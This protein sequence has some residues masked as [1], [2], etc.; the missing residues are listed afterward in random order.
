MSKKVIS[1]CV[2]CGK[3]FKHSKYHDTKTCSKECLSEYRWQNFLQEKVL[4]QI[5][6]PL[7][8]WLDE[9]YNKE[10]WSYRDFMDY[11]NINNRTV[12]KLLK[13]NNIKIRHGSKAVEAQYKRN[14]EL[15]EKSRKVFI[16]ND[17]PPKKGE[18]NPAQNP[19]V[20]KKISKAKTGHEMYQS[21]EWKTKVCKPLQKLAVN[22][23]ETNIEKIMRLALEGEGISFEAQKPVKYYVLDFAIETDNIKLD[24]EVDGT[25][26]HQKPERIKRDKNRDKDLQKAGWVVLRFSD[27]EIKNNIDKCI[28][29]IKKRV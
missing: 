13:K 2:I 5:N 23:P 1:N 6:K 21:S 3:E 18:P 7:K 12:R 26:W 16:K 14:P 28:N 9:K 22:Q 4:P 25:H 15:R 27:T 10:Y 20:G 29:E 17:L 8:E 19:E 24:I 11:L